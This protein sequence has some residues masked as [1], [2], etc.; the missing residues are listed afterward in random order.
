MS[1]LNMSVNFP[2][3]DCARG[4]IFQ[5]KRILHRVLGLP[6]GWLDG[7]PNEISPEK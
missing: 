5:L 3:E 2:L 6:S 7:S 1:I 4:A